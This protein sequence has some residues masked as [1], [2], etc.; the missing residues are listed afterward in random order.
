[1]S[2]FDV[3]ASPQLASSAFGEVMISRRGATPCSHP[4]SPLRLPR[5]V[6]ALM[7]AAWASLAAVM[8]HGPSTPTPSAALSQERA[9]D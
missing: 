6:G 9:P 2:A 1:M 8:I 7:V 3:Y 4:V 5:Q